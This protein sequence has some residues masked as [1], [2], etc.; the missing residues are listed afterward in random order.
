MT[1]E[2]CK[3]DKTAPKDTLNALPE[4]QGGTGRHRCV[5]CAYDAGYQKGLADGKGQQPAASSGL[6]GI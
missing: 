3:H 6:S 1:N 4:S 2:L 5:I